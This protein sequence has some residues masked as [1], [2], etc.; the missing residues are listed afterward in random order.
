MSK[1]KLCKMNIKYDPFV[2]GFTQQFSDVI[3]QVE[4]ILK[5]LISHHFLKIYY[6]NLLA[7]SGLSQTYFTENII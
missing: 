2:N 5:I 4:C 1:K 7:K 6:L 3:E